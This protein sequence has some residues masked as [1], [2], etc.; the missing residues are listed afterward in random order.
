MATQSQRILDYFFSGQTIAEIMAAFGVSEATVL[1]VVG[2][3]TQVPTAPVGPAGPQ[4]PAGNLYLP[5]T[6][7]AT[8]Y[9]AVL[10]DAASRVRMTKATANTFTIPANAAQAFPIGSVLEVEQAGAGTVAIAPAG[11]VTLDSLGG[12]RH[13]AGQFGVVK[14]VK[15]AADEW[16]ASGNLV[17]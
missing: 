5:I 14:I 8:D 9:S 7:Q 11:G 15:V 4:G 3:P 6:S 16:V 2:D 10:A 17:A 12:N 13:T 1:A